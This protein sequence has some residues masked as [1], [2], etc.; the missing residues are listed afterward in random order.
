MNAYVYDIN[1]T[2]K[3]RLNSEYMGRVFRGVGIGFMEIC[4]GDGLWGLGRF[5]GMSPLV[6]NW[7]GQVRSVSPGSMPMVDVIAISPSNED[8]MDCKYVYL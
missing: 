4:L 5:C 6:E 7:M 1:I 2:R 3:Q 8:F